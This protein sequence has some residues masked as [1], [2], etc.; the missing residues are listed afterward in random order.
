KMGTSCVCCVPGT[1][2]GGPRCKPKKR[3]KASGGRCIDKSNECDGMRDGKGCRGKK[4]KQCICC[5]PRLRQSQGS[6]KAK[7][8]CENYGGK[9][10]EKGEPCDG[11]LDGKGCK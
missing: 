6:C 9:C 5:L 2:G 8:S 1:R 7:P 4:G 10:I 11:Q 3:C